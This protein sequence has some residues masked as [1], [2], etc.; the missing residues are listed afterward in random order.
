[1]LT[2][3][4]SLLSVTSIYFAYD[5]YKLYVFICNF[6]GCVAK[7]LFNHRVNKVKEGQMDFRDR[8]VN[9]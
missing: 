1:M 9:R 8:K 3:Y 2:N 6:S 4:T 5:E 7:A